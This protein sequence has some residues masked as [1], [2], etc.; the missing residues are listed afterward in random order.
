MDNGGECYYK[1]PLQSLFNFISM[2]KLKLV[3]FPNTMTC[4]SAH[5]IAINDQEI[6]KPFIEIYEFYQIDR[7]VSKYSS[8]QVK[9]ADCQAS[10]TN[11]HIPQYIKII[12][13][14]IYWRRSFSCP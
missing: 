11:P 14:R 5:V 8:T 7:L 12:L 13:V 2:T 1:E 3:L 4:A 6:L 10:R 9:K